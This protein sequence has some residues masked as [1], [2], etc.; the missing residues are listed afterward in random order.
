MVE[1]PSAPRSFLKEKELS[2]QKAKL[3]AMQKKVARAREL[4]PTCPTYLR[5]R[6]AATGQPRVR[7]RFLEGLAG[8]AP[9]PASTGPVGRRTRTVLRAISVASAAHQTA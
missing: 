6:G 1:S 9:E 8:A 7:S 4:P 3:E 2:E 5:T